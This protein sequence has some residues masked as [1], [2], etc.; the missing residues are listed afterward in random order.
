MRYRTVELD[1]C[2]AETLTAP[3][4]LFDVLE[5]ILHEGM[6]DAFEIDSTLITVYLDRNQRL[7]V[8]L[9]AE[10]LTHKPEP[11]LTNAERRPS[12]LKKGKGNA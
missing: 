5:T 11:K 8:A 2:A 7:D 3:A 6:I 9:L 12:S 10:A 1:R 4:D